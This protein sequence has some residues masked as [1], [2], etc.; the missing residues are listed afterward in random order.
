MGRMWQ[1]LLLSKWKPVF[2]WLHVESLIRERQEMYYASLRASDAASNAAPFIEF[3]L[4]AILSALVELTHITAQD[5]DQVSV[6][7]KMVLDKL[8]KDIL[9][10]NELMM[11]LGL[12][13]KATFR[14]NYLQQ[15]LDLGLVEMTVPDKP[16]SRNQKYKRTS[17]T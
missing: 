17:S 6:Q 2:A 7:V 1:T 14:K 4:E 8:G 3:M 15:A 5:S 11:R 10:A 16:N 9:S 12:R 13:H